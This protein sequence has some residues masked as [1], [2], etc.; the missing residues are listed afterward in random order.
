M[1]HIVCYLFAV[2]SLIKGLDLGLSTDEV[3]DMLK[4][5][6]MY[7]EHGQLPSKNDMDYYLNSRMSK[8]KYPLFKQCALPE[9]RQKIQALLQACI[10][11]TGN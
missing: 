8:R 10:S 11:K 7:I 1:L 2:E 9:G 3:K 6:K 4:F 5:F